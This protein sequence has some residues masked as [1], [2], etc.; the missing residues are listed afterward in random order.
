M[1]I[2]WSAVNWVNVGLLAAFAFV[3]ALIG[4]IFSFNRTF[5]ALMTAVIFAAFYILWTHY[6]HGLTIPGA[7]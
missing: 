3:A 7:K 2:D 4:N 5:A 1:P 6:P